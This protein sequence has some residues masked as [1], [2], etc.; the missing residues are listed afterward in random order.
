M[1]KEGQELKQQAIYAPD[2]QSQAQLYLKD[3]T[4]VSKGN[5]K[6]F[7]ETG[8]ERHVLECA[9]KFYYQYD[10]QFQLKY[11]TATR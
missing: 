10:E 7:E 3:L 9:I 1:S 8:V 5:D 4:L 6:L 11:K 2:A